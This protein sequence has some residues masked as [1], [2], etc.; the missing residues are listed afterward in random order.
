MDRIRTARRASRPTPAHRPASASSYGR[1]LLRALLGVLMLAG[2]VTST[3]TAGRAPDGAGSGAQGGGGRGE[4]LLP[5]VFVHGGSGSAA[6]Y[7]TQALRWSSN[8]YPNLVTAIDR[9]SADP[10]VINPILDDFFDDVLARTRARK[11]YVVGHSQGVAVMNNYLDSSPERAARVAKYIGIDS[12]SGP[13]PD[14]CPGGA[15]DE[16]EWVVPCMGVWGRG[17]PARR[18]GPDRN[19]Q[20]ADQGHVEVV[21]SPESFEAQYEFFTGRR[22]RTTHVL[23]EPP[24]RVRIAG[25]AVNFPA[26]TP[27]TGVRLEIWEID[28]ATGARRGEAR[29]VAIDENG[30]WG[31]VRVNGERHY[32][33]ALVRD[34]GFVQHFYY[35]PFLRSDNL[36]RLNVAPPDS[37]LAGLV[38][39][40]DRHSVVTIQRQKEWWGVADGAGDV[41]QAVVQRRGGAVMPPPIDIVNETTAPVSGNTI[42]LITFDDNAD[43]VTN[44]GARL[45]VGAFLSGVDVFYPA[46][47]DA[48]G[49]IS[50]T[51]QARGE[52]RQQVLNVPNWPSSGHAIGVQLR[53]WTPEIASWRDCLR[54]RP[55][56]CR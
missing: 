4:P 6:Q 19:V 18:F 38:D 40:G 7:E 30:N 32:E 43:T 5:I 36:V 13:S 1:H 11:V 56:P 42:A 26:N 48:S 39:R 21:G 31:P 29:P 35:E 2:C 46:D 34:D 24:G 8:G 23:P 44:T 3:A 20:F 9:I 27:L 25:R 22:P 16:G 15:D 47:A 17:D 55:S 52:T 54:L 53:D 10:A 49:V 41:L 14:V 50:L 51:S 33:L 45:A 28:R 12:A 37:P